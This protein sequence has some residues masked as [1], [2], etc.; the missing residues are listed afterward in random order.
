KSLLGADGLDGTAD[1][2]TTFHNAAGHGHPG[3][4]WDLFSADGRQKTYDARNG[5]LL[6]FAATDSDNHW[7][8]A[9]PDRGSP[10]QPALVDAHYSARVAD[11]YLR[12]AHGL[13]W[14]VDCGHPTMQSVVHYD[15]DYVNAF[16]DGSSVVY[17]DGDGFLAREFSGGLDVV[18]HETTHGVTE[19]T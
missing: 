5:I 9:T 2:L 8:L 18:A 1:D 12:N 14:I 6:F 15:A 11:D 13:D 17:G 3:P 7:T 10:G 19:C 16:W 4:H